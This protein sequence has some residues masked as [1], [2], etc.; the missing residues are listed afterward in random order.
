MC[1]KSLLRYIMFLKGCAR[2]G[3]DCTV[4]VQSRDTNV[5]SKDS[6][7]RSPR[8]NLEVHNLPGNDKKIRGLWKQ[9][10]S[11]SAMAVNRRLTGKDNLHFRF[12]GYR[13]VPK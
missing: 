4:D 8:L 1:D 13:Y 6:R 2:Q 9:G 3:Y 10:C 11:G 7:N 5:Y 12:T